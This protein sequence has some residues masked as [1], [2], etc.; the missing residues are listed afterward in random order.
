MMVFNPNGIQQ[1][2]FNRMV[3][4]QQQERQQRRD[5]T[6]SELL[7]LISEYQNLLEKASARGIIQFGKE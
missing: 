2:I 6:T 3:L 5:A 4:V 7:R 1:E